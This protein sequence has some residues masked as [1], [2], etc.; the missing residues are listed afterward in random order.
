LLPA[1]P[2]KSFFLNPARKSDN[3]WIENFAASSE[4]ILSDLA[5]NQ[6]K[7]QHWL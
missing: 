4:K 1:K 7:W 2:A 5:A 3:C 6:L